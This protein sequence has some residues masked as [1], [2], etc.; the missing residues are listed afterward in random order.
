MHK[1]ASSR[2]RIFGIDFYGQG[3][4]R[5]Q[6]FSTVDEGN[7]DYIIGTGGFYMLIDISRWGGGWKMV[8]GVVDMGVGWLR[9]LMGCKTAGVAIAV[10]EGVELQ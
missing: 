7:I 5:L 8:W 2:A 6:D 3:Q 10:R 9:G 4:F 1:K